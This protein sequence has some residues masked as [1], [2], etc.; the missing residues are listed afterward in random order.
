MSYRGIKRGFVVVVA[1]L[2]MG[3]SVLMAKNWNVYPTMTRD[4]IQATIDQASDGDLITINGGDSVYDFSDIPILDR[5]VNEGAL[6]IIEKSLKIKGK[7]NPKFIGPDSIF[8]SNNKFWGLTFFYFQD[9][10]YNNDIIISG[11]TVKNFLR[12][13]SSHY[14]VNYPNTPD[15]YRPNGRHIT[16]RGC[17]FVDMHRNG[18]G[19]TNN[20]GDI[21]ILNNEIISSQ[22][23]LILSWRDDEGSQLYRP[24]KHPK[25]KVIENQIDIYGGWSMHLINLINGKI[26]HNSMNGG[27]NGIVGSVSCNDTEFGFN[28]MSNSYYGFYFDCAY[29]FATENTCNLYVHHNILNGIVYY[30]M[31]LKGQ[32]I[33]NNEISENTITMKP[34]SIAAILTLARFNLYLGNVIKGSAYY[35]FELGNWYRD[36]LVANNEFLE[37]NDVGEF[38][39]VGVHYILEPDTHHN[40]VIGLNG[41]G[42]CVDD[43]GYDNTVTNFQGCD[44]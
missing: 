11:I 6:N 8:E 34:N 19:V 32:R 10:D 33:L 4:E 1:L 14:N 26:L 12:G 25:I 15:I 5:G 24:D 20:A 27:F 22:N 29:S 35:A 39:A 31:I 3:G 21:T 13:F 40:T 18:I 7:H 28:Q 2:V 37:Q 17:K 43:L 9:L 36:N 38:N 42:V 23:G 41:P 44:N 16:I 30:G